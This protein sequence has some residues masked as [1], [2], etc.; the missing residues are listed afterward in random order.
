M[1]KDN[2]LRRQSIQTPASMSDLSAVLQQGHWQPAEKRRLF[3]P[4][5]EARQRR[6][7]RSDALTASFRLS[8]QPN[9]CRPAS[10]CSRD[11]TSSRV[12]MTSARGGASHSSHTH[13]H[14]HRAQPAL[15]IV[16]RQAVICPD[17]F[18]TSDVIAA[19]EGIV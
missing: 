3:R 19:N 18:C 4:T 7:R 15:H 11:A 9:I 14:T 16:L 6:K 13:T 1:V 8:Q 10:G 5:K 17:A 2:L 12:L